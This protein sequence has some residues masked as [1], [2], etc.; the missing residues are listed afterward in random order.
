MNVAIITDSF[1]P[2]MDGVS[3]CALGYAQALHD[4]GYG[5]TIVVTPR[6]PHTKYDYPF[7]VY[8]F[9]SVSFP[10]ADYRAGHPFIPYLASTL[11]E[12]EIDILHAHSPFTSMLFAR[13]LRRF[14]KIPIVFTQ[15]TKWDFDIAQAIS[16]AVLQREIEHYVYKSIA[17]ADELWAVSRGAGEYLQ[18]RG[19]KGGYVVMPNGTDF[20]KTEVDP[21]LLDDLERRYDLPRGVPVLLFVGRMMWYKNIGLIFDTMDILIKR[22]FDF[23]M[24]F[25]G[26]GEDFSEIKKTASDRGLTKHALFSGR[27]S[28]RDVLMSYYTRADLLVFL[29][30]YDNAPIVIQEAAACRCA[31]LVTRGSSTSEVLEDGVNGFFV[32]EDANCAAEAIISIF[33]DRKRLGEVSAA[34]SEQVYLPWG[35]AIR[36]AVDR[37]EYIKSNYTYKRI[38]RRPGKEP[39]D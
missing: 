10:Y 13:Q 30:T 25:V 28:D 32:D 12:M 22:G 24:F 18:S 1:P 34:A 17:K 11:K 9:S 23:R 15:H 14:L 2:M 21:A 26:D 19:Y 6:M 39:I 37:Y 33:A 35:K 4:G 27:I 31:A 7:P 5:N 36:Q 20:T 3:R 8:G 29:S 38:K 16:S